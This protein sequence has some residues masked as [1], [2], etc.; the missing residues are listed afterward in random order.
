MHSHC[1]T[2]VTTIQPSLERFYLPKRKL[3]AHEAVTPHF[4]LP[5]SSG[6]PPGFLRLVSAK[7]LFQMLRI[8]TV[9][10]VLSLFFWVWLIS[11]R[12]MSS[13][14]IH[15]MA[16]INFSLLFWLDDITLCIWTIFRLSVYLS[17]DI[18]VVCTF[19]LLWIM[20]LWAQV[21]Q[22]LLSSLLL[23]LLGHIVQGGTT[24]SCV[25]LCLIFWGATVLFSI[26]TA[27]SG[28]KFQYCK[29]IHF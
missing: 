7:W 1:S 24:R 23:I 12:V 16:Y 5:P 9:V 10:L 11:L 22:Y 29:N 6:P 26:L 21:S 19:W 18:W 2:T 8:S 13:G 4:L 15:G 28:R 17:V 14:F 20:L 25:V 3:R 27:A